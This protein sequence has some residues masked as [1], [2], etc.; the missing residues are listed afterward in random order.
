MF[1]KLAS[2]LSLSS[3]PER[4]DHPAVSKL[5]AAVKRE[6]GTPPWRWGAWPGQR[7]Q[8]QGLVQLQGGGGLDS[9]L[10]HLCCAPEPP[11]GEAPPRPVDQLPQGAS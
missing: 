4:G 6:G 11:E 1:G 2:E 10:G 3:F 5:E 7:F 9:V 8:T